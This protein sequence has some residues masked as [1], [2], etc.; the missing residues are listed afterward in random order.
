MAWYNG[1]VWIGQKLQKLRVMSNQLSTAMEER[2]SAPGAPTTDPDSSVGQIIQ[3]N[4]FRG[5]STDFVDLVAILEQMHDN[6]DALI[7]G[8]TDHAKY[9]WYFS[10][11]STGATK[12]TASFVYG[13]SWTALKRAEHMT[14]WLEIKAALEKLVYYRQSVWPNTTPAGTLGYFGTSEGRFP[15][16]PTPP[17]WTAAW[18]DLLVHYGIGGAS[19]IGN[20]AGW[21]FWAFNAPV[22]QPPIYYKNYINT[23]TVD[24]KYVWAGGGV[25]SVTSGLISFYKF[26]AKTGIGDATWTGSLEATVEVFGDTL[27]ITSSGGLVGTPEFDTVAGEQQTVV[28]DDS[29]QLIAGKY[30]LTATIPNPPGGIPVVISENDIDGNTFPG[31]ILIEVSSFESMYSNTGF[32]L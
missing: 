8:N 30:Y 16:T 32:I 1:G 14:P 5:M 31:Q 20:G 15:G 3:G 12:V 26:V 28:V 4:N 2:A 17:D 25:G 22:G 27:E 18:D 23:V 7:E 11:T 13:G 19:G 21:F 9:Q 29:I 6:I 24:Q 10:T